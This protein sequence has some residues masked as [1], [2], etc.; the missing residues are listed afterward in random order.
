MSQIL[1]TLNPVSI[2][3][4]IFLSAI[5]AGLIG[6]D[7]ERKK[8]AA[9]FRTHMLVSAA[10]ALVMMTSIYLHDTVMGGTGDM[11]RLSAQVISGIG[12]LGAGTIIFS[13]RIQQVRGLTTAA[14]LWATACMGI[15]VGCGFYFAAIVAA[16]S[17]FVIVT[18]LRNVDN[19]IK[20]RHATAIF[21]VEFSDRSALKEFV[22]TLEKAG[23]HLLSLSAEGEGFML[24]LET[25]QIARIE[26][27]LT[28]L[29]NVK[30][31]RVVVTMDM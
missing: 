20:N 7:R 4:R 21:Y 22:A 8:Q 2:T 16:L 17:F 9:G 11:G 25:K 19:H 6:L 26:D 14:S 30:G 27:L 31:V 3:V 1:M 5:L 12:F 10:S 24:N 13:G 29:E 18:L 23:A 28:E 15:A